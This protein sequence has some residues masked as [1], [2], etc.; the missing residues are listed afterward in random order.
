[1]QGWTDTCSPP[2]CQSVSGEI[3]GMEVYMKRLGLL[4]SS[5]QNKS[6]GLSQCGTWNAG[7]PAC[8]SCPPMHIPC[9]PAD[10]KA[11]AAASAWQAGWQAGEGEGAAL[12][13]A[14]RGPGPREPSSGEALPTVASAHTHARTHT[15]IYTISFFG[16]ADISRSPPPV[17]DSC[18]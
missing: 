8:L 3:F 10:R 15:Y 2:R 14:Q 7:R 17:N 6:L 4:D 18:S 9:P 13:P 1:M 12:A 16:A 5:L 11:E